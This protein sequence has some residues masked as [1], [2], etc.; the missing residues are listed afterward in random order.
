MEWL[1]V[2]FVGHFLAVFDV[3]THVVVFELGE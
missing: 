2:A 3:E 1:V